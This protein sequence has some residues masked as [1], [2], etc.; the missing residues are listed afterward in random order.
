MLVIRIYVQS[1]YRIREYASS[2][3]MKA[4]LKHQYVGRGVFGRV[5]RDCGKC[6]EIPRESS[7]GSP[8]ADRQGLNPVFSASCTPP[9]L[10]GDMPVPLHLTLIFL[11]NPLPDLGWRPRRHSEQQ[12]LLQ[13]PHTIGQARR[14][15]GRARPPLHG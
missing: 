6:V 2:K 15:R 9:C 7:E 4:L 5:P 3:K 11:V 14:H 8:S 12:H 1:D 10:L 13:A